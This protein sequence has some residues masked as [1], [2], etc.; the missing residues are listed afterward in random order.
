MGLNDK[1]V[2][3]AR[4]K[5]GSNSLTKYKKNSFGKLM[6]ESFGDPIIKILLIAFLIA[7]SF[8]ESDIYNPIN[9]ILPRFI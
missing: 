9:I 5:Y 4:E 2:L 8:S 6:L 3:E 1:E 7:F